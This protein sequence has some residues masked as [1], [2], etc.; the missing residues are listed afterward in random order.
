MTEPVEQEICIKFC[1]K[2][3]YSSMETIQMI[4]KAAVMGKLVITMTICP[5]THPISCRVFW[6][7]KNNSGDSA[8]LKPRFGALWLVAFPKT[9][10]TFEREEISD[11]G[12]DSGKYDRALDGDWENCVRSQGAYFEGD[13]GVL[14][15]MFLVSFSINVSMTWLDTFWTDLVYLRGQKSGQRRHKPCPLGS[16]NPR[17]SAPPPLS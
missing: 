10:I 9:K 2:L 12:W 7:K 1:I 8:L 16:S 15:T 17:R 13:W 14:C 3:Q 11:Y 4:Q 5:F 6:W